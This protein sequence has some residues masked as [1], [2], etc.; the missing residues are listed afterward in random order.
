[1]TSPVLAD[2]RNVSISDEQWLAAARARARDGNWERSPQAVFAELRDQV[3]ARESAGPPLSNCPY[4]EGHPPLRKF[5][6]HE[7]QTVTP[8]LYCAAC[9]GFW[10]AGDSITRGMADP[11]YVHPAL[12]AARAP[13]RCR[14][15]FGHLKPDDTCTGCGKALPPLNCPQCGKTMDRVKEQGVFLDQCTPCMGVWFDMGEITAVFHLAPPQG[16]AASTVDEHACDDEPS[17]WMVALNVLSR[18]LLPYLLL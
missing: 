10:A 1:M 17:G 4:C 15:C 13:R 18:L 7:L 14:T 9:H 3:R 12:E 2:S 5:E 16:L 6:R 11:G 8:L